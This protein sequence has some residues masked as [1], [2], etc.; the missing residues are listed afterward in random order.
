MI[1]KIPTTKYEKELYKLI[2][3]GNEFSKMSEGEKAIIYDLCIDL[4][5][6]VLFNWEDLDLKNYVHNMKLSYDKY[7]NQPGIN[8]VCASI[9]RVFPNKKATLEGNM[10]N[11]RLVISDVSISNKKSGGNKNDTSKDNTSQ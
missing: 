5:K 11:K 3:D 2:K 9:N 7:K 8:V 4:Q 6:Y 1:V 10:D